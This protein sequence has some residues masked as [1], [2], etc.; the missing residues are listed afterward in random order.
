MIDPEHC[1]WV[2]SE[3]KKCG[4]CAKKCTQNAIHLD[5]R[6]EAIELEVGNIIVATG[7]D[8]LD[9]RR[10]EHYGYGTYPNVLTS[11]EFERLTNASGPTGGKI[12]MKTLR[13]NKKTK[14]DEWVFDPDGPQPEAVA[15]VHCVGSR[16]RNYNSYCSRVCCMYS[17]KFAHLVREK[18]P[19]AE[20]FEYYI[21]MR[22]FG[23]GYEE[24]CERIRKE[25]VGLVRGRPASVT[26]CGSR[27][28]VHGENVATGRLMDQPVDMVVLSVGLQPSDGAAELAGKLGI[29]LDADGWFQELDYNSGPD[30]T[31]RDGI[32]I[33]GVCQGPKDIPDTVAQ[34]SAAAAGVLRSIIGSGK[35]CG[36][37]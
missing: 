5:A 10:I 4:A 25:G 2:Q 33:A 37:Q 22:A 17:L 30:S 18:L 32:Y 12:V 28:N 19:Q 34:A 16:D 27:L 24:F 1:L 13:Q 20:C 14:A 15:I 36:K 9:A 8:T 31:G 11:L 6:D 23:K 3:G 21:D 35:Q 29:P 26:E 7:Y